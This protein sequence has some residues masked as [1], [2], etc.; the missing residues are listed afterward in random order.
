M[1]DI[2]T[3]KEAGIRKSLKDTREHLFWTIKK[4][5]DKGSVAKGSAEIN[6]LLDEIG[7]LSADIRN[8]AKEE[9]QYYNSLN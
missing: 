6:R 7:S 8:I 3:I 9:E 2:E 5:T 4:A 1:I